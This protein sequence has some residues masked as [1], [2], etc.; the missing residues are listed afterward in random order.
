MENAINKE[1][2]VI[3]DSIFPFI[4]NHSDV[5]EVPVVFPDHI[6]MLQKYRPFVM[7][8]I[9]EDHDLYVDIARSVLK[10]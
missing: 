1:C 4:D 10:S 5:V 8:K 6:M 3:L 9:N 2:V 7:Q